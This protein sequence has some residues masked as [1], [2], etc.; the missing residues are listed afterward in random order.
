MLAELV[1]D[2]EKNV[3]YLHHQGELEALSEASVNNS[4]APGRPCWS[5]LRQQRQGGNFCLSG[6]KQGHFAPRPLCV[7]DSHQLA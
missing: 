5:I 4:V 3:F 7:S 6:K 1:R 2:S